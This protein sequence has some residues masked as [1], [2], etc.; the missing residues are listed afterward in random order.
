MYQLF[1]SSLSLTDNMVLQRR[2]MLRRHKPRPSRWF[3]WIFLVVLVLSVLVLRSYRKAV[4]SRSNNADRS[5]KISLADIPRI[6][7]KKYRVG[8]QAGHWKIDELPEEQANLRWG[9][10][11]SVAG[12]NEWELNLE[13]AQ[14][15]KEILERE[16]DIVVDILPSTIPVDYLADAFISLHADGNPD[17]TVSGFRVSTSIWDQDGRGQQLADLL[18]EQYALAVD[19]KKGPLPESNGNMT[20]YYAFNTEKF[21]HALEA[22]TPGV[23]IELG[24]LTNTTDRRL[25]VNFPEKLARG[26]AD[27]V[28]A[29]KNAPIPTP[30]PS[31]LE[32]MEEAGN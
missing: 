5:Q 18:E 8:I 9:G 14:L 7:N 16:E 32:D 15:I 10:G 28:L 13:V 21:D 6:D 23:I 24:F 1:L 29:F 31:P 26:V 2:M 27:G 17:P 20:E 25:M 11:A 19:I 4:L 22:K 30:A 3:I 12:V